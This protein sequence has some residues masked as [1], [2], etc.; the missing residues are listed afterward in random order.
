MARAL[1]LLALLPACA[2]DRF[3]DNTPADS[4]FVVADAPDAPKGC[5]VGQN[6]AK[7]VPVDLIFA[8]DQSESMDGEI[9]QV[10][11]NINKLT[12]L[13]SAT[14]LDWQVVMI[15]RPG[16]D[17]Y[18]VCIPPPLGNEGCGDNLPRF[19]RSA[20]QVLSN[21]ALLMFI[22]TYDSADPLLNWSKYI[23]RDSLKAFIPVTDDN[24]TQ[25]PPAPYWQTFDREMLGRG[26]GT[27]GTKEERNYAF[28]P[29]LGAS[30]GDP[31]VK[32]STEVVSEGPEYLEL[33]KLTGGKHFPVCATDYG[34]TFTAMADEIVGRV[35][36]KLPLPAP[37]PGEMLDPA[38]VNV[39]FT[40]SDGK[41]VDFVKDDSKPCNEGANGWQYSADKAHV[42]LCG[43]A[44]K[45]ARA[46]PGGKVEVIFGCT[47][48][49][50]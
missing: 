43:D 23:R 26:D 3:L 42:L 9:A 5:A 16:L 17:T 11:K 13:L 41:A 44:C 2:A 24:A 37:P 46:D 49:V 50:R 15:A 29:I 10:K 48:K 45:T 27:F 1:L 39:T 21:D 30:L 25:P 14:K 32:C 36:C 8:I 38:R 34:P 47:T 35:I 19:K 12:D 31:S 28:Y 4:G 33:V 22:R 7:P 18:G 6:V 40:A 20:Q